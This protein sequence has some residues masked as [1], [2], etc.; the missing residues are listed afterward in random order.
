MTYQDIF[1]EQARWEVINYFIN[2]FGYTSY[3]EVGIH[4]GKCFSRVV[5]DL[6]E[7]VDIGF[8]PT[9]KM[10]SDA[11][12]RDHA[13]KRYDIIFIDA[14]HERSQ[15]LKDVNG[16]LSVLNDGGTIICHDV[17][18]ATERHLNSLLCSNAW[19]AFA[20]LRTTRDDLEI[21]TLP[22]DHLGIIRRGNQTPYNG[23]WERTW[24]FL[25]TH[26]ESLMGQ[27]T[28]D[29]FLRIYGDVDRNW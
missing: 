25:S 22:F 8:N 29:E 1:P 16:A 7:S 23:K 3:L 13:D 24:E 21:H 28:V 17:N 26:R 18:P 9:F 6:K 10:T 20:E 11:F 2:T 15:L 14:N 27:L 4:S 5:C 19:E 12:F